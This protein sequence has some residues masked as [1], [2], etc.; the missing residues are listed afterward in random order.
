MSVP[1]NPV[2]RHLPKGANFLAVVIGFAVVILIALVVAWFM[3]GRS[4]KKIFPVNTKSTPSQTR[5]MFPPGPE[6]V[7]TP[8]PSSA[9][10]AA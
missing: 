2:D 10:A 7:M 8:V 4:G 9:P 1:T 6:P 5:L 3:V